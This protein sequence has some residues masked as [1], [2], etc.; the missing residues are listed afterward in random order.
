MRARWLQKQRSF[1][2]ISSESLDV[3][4]T[5]LDNV[6]AR[7]YVDQQCLF[8]HKPLLESGTLGTMGN[9]QIVVPMMT[10]HYG[11]TRDPPEASIPVCTL[12]NFP[13]QIEH[14]LQ[15]ARDWFEGE[16]KQTPEDCNLYLSSTDFE[17]SLAQQQ[18][19]IG[20]F[21]ALPPFCYIWLLVMVTYVFIVT[22]SVFLCFS[23]PNP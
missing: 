23:R 5:A 13:N 12:K 17:T 22:T 21:I 16:F 15:W 18:V 3:V 19:M 2:T 4:C 11:A 1:L 9:T 14:T 10:Q 7:L 20:K 8:Y 6:E